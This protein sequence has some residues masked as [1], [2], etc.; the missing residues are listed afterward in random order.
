MAWRFGEGEL[1]C[2]RCLQTRDAEEVDRL[3]WCDECKEAARQRATAW[4]WVLGAVIAGTLAA[5]IWLVIEP[6]VIVAG[7]VGAVLAAFYLT[8]RA[9]REIIFATMRIRNRQAVEAAPPDSESDEGR[10][11]EQG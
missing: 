3:L 6:E 1:T 11:T 2:G 4:G 5:V 8:A 7:W 10:S 9:S